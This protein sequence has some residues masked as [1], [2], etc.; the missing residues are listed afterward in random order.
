MNK[1]FIAISNTESV[2]GG[3]VV[4][5]RN[6]SDALEGKTYGEYVWAT[7][8]G[9]Q[10]WEVPPLMCTVT[11]LSGEERKCKSDDEFKEL[12]KLYMDIS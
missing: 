4:T 7:E 5:S 6:I 9:K 11:L 8:K 2:T 1:C 12:I 3:N 10:F